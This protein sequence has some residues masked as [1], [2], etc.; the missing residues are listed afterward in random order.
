M[1]DRIGTGALGRVRNL[2]SH[3]DW[4]I[5]G[6]LVPIIGAGLVTMNSFVSENYFFE[7]Q[8]LSISIA[9][10]VFFIISFIDFRFLRR[11]SV[12]VVLFS[13]IAALLIALFAFG[14]TF[15]GA[16]SWFTLGSFAFQPA[17]FAK[18]ILVFVLAKY[19]ARRHIE[20]AHVRHI[21][22]S[23]LYAFIFFALVFLQPDFGSAVIIF[24]VW[25]GM[26]LVSGVS[27]KHLLAVF[28]L[29]ICTFAG[30]WFFVFQPYQ[31]D[32]IISFVSPRAD[33][34][35]SGY[36]AFQSTIAVGSGQVMGKGLGF[37]TQSRLKFLPEYQT[38]FVFSAFAEEWGFVGVIIVFSAYGFF[39]V[40]ILR[41]ASRGETNFEILY[42]LGLAIFFMSHFFIN[43]GMNIG[44]LP[45][46]GTP[47]PFMSYGG[48]HV[49]TEFIGLGVLMGMRRY[50]QRVHKDDMKKEFLGV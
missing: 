19:F 7:K 49:L 32:R 39:V 48:T 9:L 11:T 15:K 37:G 34:S 1:G 33:I 44:L 40:R 8:V 16:Q 38:D 45:I 4:W 26:I 23:G 28:L 24:F 13:V 42:G 6:A 43:A 5:L 17:D 20:I 50:S 10:G 41:I 21:L 2:F 47:F 12:I 31:K 36:N 25:F 46:T 30:L 29:G 3:I 35:G 18:L 27:W 14:Q 22:V